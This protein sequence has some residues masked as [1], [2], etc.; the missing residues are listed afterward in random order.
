MMDYTKDKSQVALARLRAN[1][2]KFNAYPPHLQNTLFHGFMV[3]RLRKR[4]ILDR[5][6][7][8]NELRQGGNS[9]YN[10]GDYITAANC[11]EQ[12]LGLLY[13]LQWSPTE[14]VDVTLRELSDEDFVYVGPM[15]LD[16]HDSKL[17]AG[18]TA[19]L[20]LN[21]AS[22]Y[23]KLQYFPQARALLE[24]LVSRNPKNHYVL[25][26]LSQCKLCCL[27]S[28]RSDLHSALD[29]INSAIKLHSCDEYTELISKVTR[30]I[31]DAENEERAFF[32]DFFKQVKSFEGLALS[33]TSADAEFEHRVML[34]LVSKYPKMIQFY[35]DNEQMEK[36]P[37]FRAEMAQAQAVL[38]RMNWI[39]EIAANRPSPLMQEVADSMQIDLHSVHVHRAIDR[40]KRLFIVKAFGAGKYSNSLVVHCI[41]ECAAEEERRKITMASAKEEGDEGDLAWKLGTF[42][43]MVLAAVL[44]YCATPAKGVSRLD[45][46]LK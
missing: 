9:Q 15:D 33:D 6:M 3:R 37:K 31:Q 2:K 10:K 27:D 1:R 14:E 38:H 17:V 22:A 36:I 12:G 46:L 24:T 23:M 11:Y 41:E 34:K 42:A 30:K 5:V 45:L 21:L 35:T 4:G 18:T 20:G 44:Y 32:V 8:A 7:A 16:A 13:W 26:R 25:A 29:L 28:T 19:Q 40:S 39:E 43:F